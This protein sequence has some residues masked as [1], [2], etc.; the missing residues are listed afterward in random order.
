MPRKWNKIASNYNF[1]IIGQNCPETN[2]VRRDP[3]CKCKN[4]ST[5]YNNCQQITQGHQ[6]S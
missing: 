4:I 1:S 3:Y 5:V 6:I 2:T